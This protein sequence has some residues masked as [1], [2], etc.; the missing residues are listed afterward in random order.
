MRPL[1]R[2]PVTPPSLPAG[3]AVGASCGWRTHASRDA[4]A[5][6]V[7]WPLACTTKGDR[8]ASARP[9]GRQPGEA[10][11]KL[12]IQVQVMSDDSSRRARGVGHQTRVF[13]DSEGVQWEVTEVPGRNVPAARGEKCLIFSSP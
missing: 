9:H 13:T 11:R 1:P 12:E 5:P 4:R 2:G 6:E 10:A 3:T 8:A 7:M